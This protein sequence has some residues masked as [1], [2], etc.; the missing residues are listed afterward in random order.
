MPAQLSSEVIE[1]KWSL[2][3]QKKKPTDTC[4]L[5]YIG[6]STAS[7]LCNT[8]ACGV[9][10]EFGMTSATGCKYPQKVYPPPYSGIWG[11][12]IFLHKHAIS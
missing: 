3:D 11:I 5:E 12:V 6:T 9:L 4:D 2:D 8:Y 10:P 7:R 1:T